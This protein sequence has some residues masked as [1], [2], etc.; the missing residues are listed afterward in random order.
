MFGSAVLFC[1]LLQFVFVVHKDTM[2]YFSLTISLMFGKRDNLATNRTFC[3]SL[4]QVALPWSQADDFALNTKG[5]PGFQR[6]SKSFK[7]PAS[8]LIQSIMVEPVPAKNI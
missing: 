2:A 7:F 6:G 1:H 3:Y 4:A 5:P 8:L